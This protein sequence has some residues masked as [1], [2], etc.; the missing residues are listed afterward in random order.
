MDPRLK[1]AWTAPCFALALSLTAWAGCGDA[2]DEDHA[3]HDN[4]ATNNATNNHAG[5]NNAANNNAASNNAATNNAGNNHAGHN[6][7]TSNNGGGGDGPTTTPLTQALEGEV[8][9]VVNGGDNTLSAL[10]G[11]SGE[12]LGVL[13]FTGGSYPHHIYA[14]PDGATLSVAFPGVD[15]SGGHGG[16]HGGHGA[17]TGAVALLDAKTGQT[18]ASS[19]LPASNHNAAF[20]PDGGEVWTALSGSPGRVLIL[21]SA[22]LDAL[23]E[24][25]VGDGP[26]EVTF[27]GGKAFVANGASGDVTVIDAASREVLATIPVGETPVGAWPASDGR[28]Y[29]DNEGD[30]SLSVIDAE[31]LSV[32][33]TYDLG[34]TPALALLGPDGLLWV[35]DAEHGKVVRFEAATATR[36]DELETGAGA[37]AMA[38]SGDGARAFVTNQEDDTVSLVD[39]ARFEVSATVEVGAAPNGILWLSLP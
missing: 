38:F 34:F 26:S 14:S 24:V 31:D 25:E 4:S 8:V 27:L 16:G 20:S 33:L 1:L 22:T 6:N 15:L 35:T 39:V 23:G 11:V 13:P 12:A 29:V 5:H 36:V 9:F 17:G 3:D 2:H 32:V 18:R 19:L 30:K 28:L 37:H 10:D 21:D 7:A